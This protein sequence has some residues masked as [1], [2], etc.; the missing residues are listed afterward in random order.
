MVTV[1][2]SYLL[3]TKDVWMQ[4]LMCASI[5]AVVACSLVLILCLSTPFAGDVHISNAVYSDLLQSV[6][7]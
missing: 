5:T 7:P 3:G 1:A 6:G 2:V 4:A